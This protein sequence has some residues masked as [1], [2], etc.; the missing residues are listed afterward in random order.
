M[1]KITSQ[2]GRFIASERRWGAD[3]EIVEVV[4]G[5][6]SRRYKSIEPKEIPGLLCSGELLD[7][8]E[9]S[10]M[11]LNVWREKVKTPTIG[12]GL[13]SLRWLVLTL[14]IIQQV[15]EHGQ[16]VSVVEGESFPINYYDLSN[17]IDFFLT[18]QAVEER[19]AL[20]GGFH[21]AGWLSCMIEPGFFAGEP[22]KYLTEAG[23]ETLRGMV[24]QLHLMQEA[25]DA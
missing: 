22:G 8:L 17:G 21:A 3:V 15:E 16:P 9:L 4:N 14:F 23:A 12:E 20:F 6:Q 24:K 25:Q 13:L 19:G 5:E 18:A 11:L 1:K 7:E 10:F 2:T